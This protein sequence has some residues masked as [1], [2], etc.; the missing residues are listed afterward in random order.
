MEID[1]EYFSNSF[2]VLE[3]QKPARLTKF[4]Y[5]QP[6]AMLW[7]IEN[8]GHPPATLKQFFYCV[9]EFKINFKPYVHLNVASTVIYINYRK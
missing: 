6:A 7:C 4:S 9:C 1:L 3:L 5:W 2:R 8:K